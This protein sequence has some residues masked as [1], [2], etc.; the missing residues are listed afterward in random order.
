MRWFKTPFWI[1]WVMPN[2]LWRAPSYDLQGQSLVYLTFDD[3]PISEVTPWVL[4]QL[5]KY[6]AKATFFCI[7]ENAQRYPEI[8]QETIRR[9]HQIGNHTQNHCNG[10]ETSTDEY[11]EQVQRFEHSTGVNTKLFRPPYGRLNARQSKGVI[12]LGYRIVMWDVL[13]YDWQKELSANTI[14]DRLKK[15]IK[16]GSIIVFHDSVKAEKNL[17][18]VLPEILKY[19]DNQ[20]MNMVGL[21]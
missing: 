8:L 16:P 18:L 11:L 7:G 5:D 12:R 21:P 20:K 3:G 19:L 2:R 13:S 10:R 4:E 15:F 6:N 14:I 1:P 9:G 17:R